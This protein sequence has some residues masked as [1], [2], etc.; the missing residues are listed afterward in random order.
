[1]TTDCRF[2]LKC[3]L[4]FGIVLCMWFDAK[5]TIGAPHSDRPVIFDTP[6]AQKDGAVVLAESGKKSN[7][8]SGNR[9]RFKSPTNNESRFSNRSGSKAEEGSQQNNRRKENTSEEKKACEPQGNAKVK[10]KKCETQSKNSKQDDDVEGLDAADT[11]K[12]L[13]DE[14]KKDTRQEIS[15]VTKIGGEASSSLDKVAPEIRM[16]ETNE[17]TLDIGPKDKLGN[18]E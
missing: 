11:A 5:M 18:I 8:N 4:M 14:N 12:R 7:S 3:C 9:S 13:H 6:M 17:N 10:N 1:M 15:D 2:F 16:K